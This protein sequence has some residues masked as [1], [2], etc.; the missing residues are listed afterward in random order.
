MISAQARDS[1]E[2]I[3][4]KA[5]RTRLAR[6]PDAACDIV[7]IAVRQTDSATPDTEVAIG[8][9]HANVVVLTISSIGF[10]MLLV[11]HFD[12]DDITTRYFAGDDSDKP[13]REVFLEI[14]NLCCGAI[15]QE[16]LN[17]FPDL[18][19]STPYVL[20][21]R[22]VP[23]LMQLK[24]NHLAS[25]DITLDGSVRLAATLCVCAHAPLD[26]NAELSETQDTSGELELF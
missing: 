6:T 8:V 16:L 10:R 3:L 17:Y 4:H 1:F 14:S 9:R 25:W 15:N 12:E 20:S 22:C 18:G 13:F 24:P 7:P 19:M 21:A 26:F 2:R 11:L 5:A 23:H